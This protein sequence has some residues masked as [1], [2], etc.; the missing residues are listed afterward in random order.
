MFEN[1]RSEKTETLFEPGM[2]GPVRF[3]RSWMIRGE[4]SGMSGYRQVTPDIFGIFPAGNFFSKYA[5]HVKR[6]ALWFEPESTGSLKET[7]KI[8]VLFPRHAVI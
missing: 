2:Y 3:G 6:F 5:L 8:L 1:I 4:M 7:N